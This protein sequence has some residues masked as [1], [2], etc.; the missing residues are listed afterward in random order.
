MVRNEGLAQGVVPLPPLA[1]HPPGPL[2]SFRAQLEPCFFPGK[3][4]PSFPSNEELPPVCARA[5]FMPWTHFTRLPPF[6][7]C[8]FFFFKIAYFRIEA[9]LSVKSLAFTC[10]MFQKMF[11]QKDQ[12]SYHCQTPPPLSLLLLR[13]PHRGPGLC[14]GRSTSS[15]TAGD[16]AQVDT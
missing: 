2:L 14:G 13:L 5:P 16:A 9:V 3:P 4:F 12:S 7:L 8:F 6:P 11:S 15:Y 10:N 1:W